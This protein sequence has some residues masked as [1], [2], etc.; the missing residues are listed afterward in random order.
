[1]CIN[2][3]I[4]HTSEQKHAFNYIPPY[5]N[6]PTY[7]HTTTGIHTYIHTNSP[8]KFSS[9]KWRESGA[10]TKKAT[11]ARTPK[12]LV[13][14]HMAS[15]GLAQTVVFICMCMDMF[16][17]AGLRFVT[18]AT[19]TGGSIPRYTCHHRT[20]HHRTCHHRTCHHR[21]WPTGITARATTACGPRASPHVPPP[22]VAHGHYRTW[23]H[24][25]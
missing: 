7:I 25:T 24:R 10:K 17:T 6:I 12:T 4:Y 16:A 14:I 8:N 15:S 18:R 21:T 3:C 19:T 13:I 2:W 22:H 5:N 23:H 9:E 20:C 1:M 11:S